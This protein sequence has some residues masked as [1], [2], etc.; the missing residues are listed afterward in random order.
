MTFSSIPR[1]LA[2][3]RQQPQWDG[4]PDPNSAEG[5]QSQV[6]H[7]HCPPPALDSTFVADTEMPFSSF[8]DL[9]DEDE[10][11]TW[12][13]ANADVVISLAPR[14]TDD[15]CIPSEKL[16][17]RLPWFKSA[18]SDRWSYPVQEAECSDTSRSIRL[19]LVFEDSGST[20]LVRKVSIV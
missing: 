13:F 19:E 7:I 17:A 3:T 6:Y 9:P 4:H 2:N 14:E 12:R 8:N 20:H 15:L 1:L 11:M 5:Q 18:L 10:N 16:M